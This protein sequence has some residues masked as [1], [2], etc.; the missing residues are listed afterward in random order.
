MSQ[1]SIYGAVNVYLLLLV[2]AVAIDPT[3]DAA[4]VE[5]GS[6]R[7]HPLFMIYMSV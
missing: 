2:L 5:D 4:I 7:R 6:R 3:V 1:A